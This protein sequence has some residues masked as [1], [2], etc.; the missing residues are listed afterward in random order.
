MSKGC[1]KEAYKC[2]SMLEDET[3]Q[4]EVLDRIGFAR[5]APKSK[6]ERFSLKEEKTK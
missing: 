6:F 2:A 5:K 1:L 4:T 3:R